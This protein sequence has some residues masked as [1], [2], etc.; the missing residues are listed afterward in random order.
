MKFLVVHEFKHGFNT[1]K[2]DNS[3]DSDDFDDI[4]ESTVDVF[5]RAGWVEI[6]GRETNAINPSHSEVIADNVGVEQN[7]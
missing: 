2:K 3:H 6:E 4:E 1:F 5:W 7:G